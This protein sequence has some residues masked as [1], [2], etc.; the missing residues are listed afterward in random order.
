MNDFNPY[1]YIQTV[2]AKTDNIEF[3]IFCH[4]SILA[5]PIEIELASNEYY[6]VRYPAIT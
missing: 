5:E 6:F 4:G 2:I 1:D 3:R